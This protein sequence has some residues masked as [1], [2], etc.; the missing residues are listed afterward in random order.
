MTSKGQVSNLG[1]TVLQPEQAGR[2]T[3]FTCPRSLRCV[4]AWS[5]LQSLWVTMELRDDS[6]QPD[7]SRDN[8]TASVRC[9]LRSVLSLPS[10]EMLNL[11]VE[12]QWPGRQGP[13]ADWTDGALPNA[14]DLRKVYLR[15]LSLSAA[16]LQR[17]FALPLQWLLLHDCFV[18]DGGHCTFVEAEQSSSGSTGELSAPPL[19]SDARST[20][21]SGY[22]LQQLWFSGPLSG[23]LLSLVASQ[24]QQLS[25]LSIGPMDAAA[26]SDS[27]PDFSALMTASGA[28][29]LKQLRQLSLS[30][31]LPDQ[32]TFPHELEPAYTA[33]CQQLVAAY[34]AQLTALD[35]S[36]HTG[37]SLGS[38]LRLLFSHCR[39]LA[40]LDLYGPRME[41]APPLTLPADAELPSLPSLRVLTFDYLSL[42]DGS[43]LSVLIRCPELRHC[44]LDNLRHVTEAGQERALRC[45]PRL[46]TQ[47]RS[48][49]AAD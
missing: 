25:V 1:L 11:D 8:W 48:E 33:A 47:T 12:K 16:S 7:P 45:C 6:G 30:F 46:L 4:P 42:T 20:Q 13:E 40:S 10:L 3:L 28:S 41:R 36:V 5:A 49:R 37:S 26:G 31:G 22:G 35:L 32:V 17:L 38:W 2:W 23:G 39:Q 18:H 9:L 43:L 24:A 15:R 34:S 21:P 19:P 44:Y 27:V 29:R 14:A